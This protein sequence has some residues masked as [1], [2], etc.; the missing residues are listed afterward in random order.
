MK[1][2]MKPKMT[3]KTKC[4]KTTEA[5]DPKKTGRFSSE[6][7]P[8]KTSLDPLN[9]QNTSEYRDDMLELMLKKTNYAPSKDPYGKMDHVT[10]KHRVI[11]MDWMREIT[12][13][14]RLKC[15]TLFLA[16]SIFDQFIV[17]QGTG[18]KANTYGTVGGVALWIASKYEEIVPFSV[19]NIKYILSNATASSV[20][21]RQMECDILNALKFDLVRAS[22][23]TFLQHVAQVI[24]LG[25]M[26]PNF[27]LAKFFLEITVLD[28]SLQMRLN[29]HEK[30]ATSLFLMF[31]LTEMKPMWIERLMAVTMLEL[32][33]LQYW[34]DLVKNTY[35]KHKKQW[36]TQVYMKP[37]HMRAL[38][39]LNDYKNKTYQEV[40]KLL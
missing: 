2:K 38:T 34:A 4:E 18:M 3:P 28:F 9:P 35:P 16:V 10:K 32:Q 30:A 26:T 1:P 14:Y 33:Q 29:S 37:R 17:T 8:F 31:K 22:P 39:L 11:M 21:L 27:W 19:K 6:N 13:K 12:Y 23:L 20:S 25:F 40:T 5:K 36:V 7:S 24:G 15:E